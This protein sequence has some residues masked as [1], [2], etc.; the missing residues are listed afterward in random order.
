M[1]PLQSQPPNLFLHTAQKAKWKTTSHVHS[2]PTWF[3]TLFHVLLVVKNCGASKHHSLSQQLNSC[4]DIALRNFSH[5]L[6][7]CRALVICQ[8][9]LKW[10][11]T[12]FVHMQIKSSRLRP[13]MFTVITVTYRKKLLLDLQKSALSVSVFLSSTK[14]SAKAAKANTWLPLSPPKNCLAVRL[15]S[16]VH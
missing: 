4:S 11:K 2:L 10:C 3:M 5:H 12:L 6:Q 8:A 14:V 1:W 16:V 7:K 13:S 9:T 15:A